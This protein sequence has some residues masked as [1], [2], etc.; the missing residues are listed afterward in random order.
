MPDVVSVRLHVSGVGV[1]VDDADRVE[2]EVESAR[3]WSRCPLCGFKCHKVWDRWV[4]RM[5]DLE[6]SG[7]RTTLVWRRC[8]FW[9]GNCGGGTWRIMPSSKLG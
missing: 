8:R 6:V 4:K 5:R 2:A 7:R 9:C 1:L 3:G